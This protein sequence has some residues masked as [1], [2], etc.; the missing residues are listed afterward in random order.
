[1]PDDFDFSSLSG[2][3]REAGRKQAREAPPKTNRPTPPPE[4]TE[5]PEKAAARL[6]GAPP[7]AMWPYRNAKGATLF[8]VCRWSVVKGGQS[9]KEIRP[10]CWFSNGGW[11]FA[12][13]PDPRPL[14]NLDQLNERPSAPVIVC[15]GEP[16]ADA[17]RELFR[18]HVVVT[19]CGGA[20]A[21]KS[22][23]WTPLAGRPVKI[24]SDND[25]PGEDYARDVAEILAEL[26][27]EIA[28]VDVAALAAIDS[29][30]READFDPDGWDAADAVKQWKD[31]SALREAV[32][33]LTKPFHP[34][35]AFVSF[36]PYKMATRGLTVER[37]NG[38]TKRMETRWIAAPF[39]VRGLCRDPRGD[40]WAK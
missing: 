21:A 33:K 8:W 39:E 20:R 26:D 25:K 4:D 6:F 10:L 32:I 30:A 19:S 40:G 12:H 16:A 1:M 9:D 3:E 23:D 11:R 2:A 15:E 28:I 5:A 34:A 27:C 7:D 14:Y 22:S 36:G 24:W 37:L 18:D 38:K 29:G 35:P 13:L 17:A 31:S